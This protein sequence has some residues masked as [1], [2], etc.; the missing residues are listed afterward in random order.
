MKKTTRH[1]GLLFKLTSISTV[2][3]FL[4]II[5][6][7]I[8]SITS[9]KSSSSE[10]AL[11]MGKG[12]ILSDFIHFEERIARTY[13][14]LRLEGGELV[15]ENGVSLRYQYSLID[16]LSKELEIA[17]TIFMREN[18]DYRRVTT[19]IID[20][21]GKRA[22]DTFLGTGSA[23]YPHIQAGKT[24]NGIAKILGDNYLT[25]YKPILAP[26]GR[27]VIGIMFIGI[28]MAEINA[29]IAA[30]IA[31]GAVM[32]VIIASISILM[33]IVVNVLSI[34][35][36][37]IKPI[38][39]VTGML[40]ELAA[41]KGDLT[42]H[43]E[44]ASK[45]EIGDLAHYFHLTLENIKEM[46][47]L[48][49]LKVNALTN[50]G[51]ELSVNMEKTTASVN[52]ITENF[53]DI[54]K[55]EEKQHQGSEEVHKAMEQINS[56]IKLQSQLIEEQTTSVNTSSSAI[57]EMTA[58][59]NSVNKT[60][61]ENGKNVE[62]LAEA[63]EHGR[64]ALQ[65]VAQAIQEIAKDSEGL[66]EINAVMNNIASQTNLL[67]M[68]AAIEAAHAGESGK[69]FAVV[70]DEIRKLAESSG[71]QSKTTVS[72]LK[73]IKA[74]I[75]SI[76]KTSDEVLARFGVIDTG[77]QT[78][79]RHELNIRNTME[80]QATGGQ[81]ILEAVSRLK[82]I[83][84]S[85]QK[86]S[87]NM[88]QSGSHLV[89]ETDSFIKVSNQAI[90]SMNE[91]VSGALEEIRT[92]VAHVTEMSAENNQNFEGL[93][94]ET[95]KFKTSTGKE[96]KKILMVDD[97]E[98]HLTMTKGFLEDNYDVITSKSCHDALKQLYQGL[99]PG[100][101]LLDL[102]MPEIGGWDTYERFRALSKLHNVP[103]AIFTSSEDPADRERAQKMGAAD[104]IR[105]PC[106]KKELL[107]RINT[108]MAR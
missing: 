100:F 69:G 14:Q 57:E 51:Y 23:A 60:L 2:F 108:I 18:N 3:I 53:S 74:S 81:Q 68:N 80:E 56:N 5:A 10:T 106:Q 96:H 88:S 85:V 50:T 26:N 36:I 105:K 41:G 48:I 78:V 7:S 99:D 52:A 86:G 39:N 63:S 31:R 76:T 94:Q 83:T 84:V 42:R 102:M 34:R 79:S 54:R 15:G 20:H 19:S 93:K 87:E 104:Y 28:K 70:A 64:S 24:Y 33:L 21:S 8:F 32:I 90:K 44:I 9:V 101:I 30:N 27:D 6:L 59:I 43:V 49:K 77:V 98:T 82:E 103:I 72:M 89:R 11:I 29:V 38:K 73:K 55:L 62:E 65:A 45:D 22:V 95:A 12:K 91:I 46:V 66:L 40:R 17:A 1:I 75:D 16:T 35:I 92:A 67:S 97:D 58:N 25:E 47:N 4:S 107:E 13:G 61:A 71:K 37:L